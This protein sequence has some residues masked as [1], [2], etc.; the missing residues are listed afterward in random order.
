M[1]R[2][3][4]AQTAWKSFSGLGLGEWPP[5][6]AKVV[7]TATPLSPQP[8]PLGPRPS[9]SL[10]RLAAFAALAT[11]L[12]GQPL[13]AEPVPLGPDVSIRRLMT[14]GGNG[15]RLVTNPLDGS[16][17]YLKGT[18]EI[19]RLT[20]NLGTNTSTSTLLYTTSDHGLLS[21]IGFTIGPD[22]TIYVM[23]NQDVLESK[24]SRMRLVKGVLPAAGP[25]TWSILA[26]TVAY[27]RSATAYDHAFAGLLVTADGQFILVTSGSRTDHGEVESNAGSFPDTREVPLTA[28][29]LKLPINAAGTITLQNDKAWLIANN[30]LF[31][32]GV[33]NTFDLAYG[34]NGDIFGTDNGPDADYPEEINWLRE[35]GHFGFPW[36]L[37]GLDNRT[38]FAGYNYASD[39]LW[40]PNWWSYGRVLHEGKRFYDYDPE[41]PSPPPV[42]LEAIQ[43][44]GPDAD[45]IRGPDDRTVRDAQSTGFAMHSITPHRA[46]LG[47]VFDTA[48]ALGGSYSGD[49]FFLSWTAGNAAG[50]SYNGPFLDAS[51][52]LVQ[53]DNL[54]R[55]AD[56][57][58]YTAN[59]RKVVSGF[60]NPIDAAVLQDKVYVLE[61]GAPNGI[62]E[63]TFRRSTPAS[64]TREV[65]TGISGTSLSNIPLGMAPSITDTLPSLEGPTNWA[66]NYGTRVR[67][68]LT[69][70]ATGNY[71][72][73]IAGDDN[74][75]LWISSSND[76]ANKVKIGWVLGYTDSRQWNKYSSQKSPAITL[77]QGQQYYVEALQKEGD[78]GDNLA[79]GWAKPD[80]PTSAPSE[81]N[82]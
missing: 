1:L 70:P 64:I 9:R 31:A 57:Q 58:N 69:A 82:C 42:M 77:T 71:T 12:A 18:G 68:Y 17:Y 44:L 35:G 52:D 43:N 20:I 74:C 47:I 36:R 7:P 60:Q 75:E 73:W 51:Q 5:G 24:T 28:V 4:P 48:R 41:F 16:L 14:V 45:S 25:R 15:V 79:V 34:P 55:T 2:E 54:A 62:Y 33:R 56:G 72:F 61:Y 81:V 26:E 46:P 40:N 53:L 10:R 59:F 29:V 32:E 30:Y 23:G 13:G 78:G 66:D 22:G 38:R 67:G 37:G 6:L 76:P 50:D 63:L 80:E 39:T 11:A 8:R 65:W 49:G 3:L 21:T 27:P 19:Y